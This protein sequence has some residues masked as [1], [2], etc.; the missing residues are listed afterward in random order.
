MVKESMKKTITALLQI[1]IGS[2]A[3]A[4]IEMSSYTATG[5]AGVSV[6]LLS[7]YQCQGINPANLA[8]KPEFKKRNICMGFGEFGFSIYSDALNLSGLYDGLFNPNRTLSRA[9][10]QQA[11]KD[12]ATKALTA[13]LDFLYGGVSWQSDNGLFGLA[14]TI[15][16]RAQWYSKFSPLA[17]EVMFKGFNAQYQNPAG[18]LE[19][20]FNLVKDTIKN[21]SNVPILDENGNIQIDT[22]GLLNQ[23]GNVFSISRILEGS[24]ISMLWNREFALDYGMNIIDQEDFQLNA[25]VGIRY[26]QGIGYLDVSA[27]ERKLNA[28]IAASPAFGLQFP[29]QVATPQNKGFF[30]NPVGH[31]VGFEFGLS[32]ELR[33]RWRIGASLTDIGS[34]S[35]KSNSYTADDSPLRSLSTR[36]FTNFNFFQDPKQFESF[37]LELVKWN[38]TQVMTQS[39][40]SKFRVGASLTTKLLNLGM[41]IVAP[42]NTNPGNLVKPVASIGGDIKL[43]GIIQLSSGFMIGGNYTYGLVPLGI[44]VRPLGPYYEFGVATRDIFTYLRPENP[45][46]SMSFGF[47]RIRI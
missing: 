45:M 11:A 47:C 22:V 43:L 12:F 31:G 34:I 29:Q 28:S 27:S 7:D 13:N 15:R 1:L 20:L 38:G 3:F 6:T 39:L 33:K 25:G 42:L 30:P 2:S 40:P 46:L 19:N 4:Q 21:I 10:K 9:E 24:R 36:G 16:E 41:E 23:V 5:R 8:F 35:Y 26:I 17:S 14:F 32:M 18:Q 37:N 44:T